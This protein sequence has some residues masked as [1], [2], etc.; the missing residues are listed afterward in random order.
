LK[1]ISG[2]L[3]AAAVVVSLGVMTASLVVADVTPA[4][5]ATSPNRA[6]EE[7]VYTIVFT[8][9]EDL[10]EG[11]YIRIDFPD[12][13]DIAAV[14]AGN[15]LV[16]GA[17]VAGIT[18]VD[19]RLNIQLAANHTAGPRGVIV[20]NV[21]N[22]TEAGDY[23][24]DISTTEEPTSVE[25]E[26]YTIA[27]AATA[28]SIKISPEEITIMAGE[29]QA[30]TA[31][32]YDTYEN[33]IGD[34]TDETEF[35]IVEPN[36]GGEW[37]AGESEDNV[38]TSNSVGE[39]TVTGNYTGLTDTATLIVEPGAPE[40]LN[41]TRQPTDATAGEV[42]APA[43]TVNATDEYGQAIP[44]LSITVS[45]GV[46]EGE[47]TLHGTLTQE[48]DDYGVATFDDLWIDLEGEY[49]LVFTATGKTIESEAF[50]I[51]VGATAQ[52]LIRP[53]TASI[54]AGDSQ[55]YEADLADEFGNVV[56]PDVTAS[57]NF[58]IDHA[59]GGTAAGNVVNATIAGTWEV[60]GTYIPDA[61][62]TGTATLTVEPAAAVDLAISPKVAKVTSGEKQT[63]TAAAEDEFGNT[64]TVTAQTVFEIEPEAGGEW[65]DNVYTSDS[66]GRWT[67]TGT[68]AGL[69][70][71]ANL[72]VDFSMCF[73][74]TAAY[75]T[76]M[77]EEIQILREFR[78]EYLLTNPL[79]RALVDLYYR[80]SPPIAQFIAEHPALQLA[81]RAMLV[82][83]LAMSTIAVN[84]TL[85][86]PITILSLVLAAIAVAAWATRRRER[87]D[88]AYA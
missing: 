41:I 57:V 26:T 3:L 83:A 32:A 39:W 66:R 78:D 53:Q 87:R 9:T 6:G 24:L 62:I 40:T 25:S 72:E 64:L 21:I 10:A 77:A 16:D 36:H 63:Y 18:K 38:Y 5:V 2:I 8:T 7:A 52:L 70:D 71:S 14:V 13:T 22:P 43:V 54:T 44:E 42:I 81:V 30:Y 27:A 55:E 48:T 60:T 12:G 28:E 31:E 79:G 88:S 49:K 56:T 76:P 51:A 35:A 47:G 33:L 46:V 74:A 75:G 69:E 20:H 84:T 61:D 67:V 85:A 45:L 34:V 50:N 19:E 1:K 82:P 29:T 23:T 15:V 86:T 73:I 11:D 4:T 17:S 65:E 68:Y 59:S 37:G 80:V 58:E